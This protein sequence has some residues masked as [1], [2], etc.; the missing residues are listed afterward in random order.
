[1]MKKSI[2]NRIEIINF[3]FSYFKYLPKIGFFK[4]R[5]SYFVIIFMSIIP[6]LRLLLKDKPNFL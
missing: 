1:M 6:L 4:S 5:F 3:G 2:D